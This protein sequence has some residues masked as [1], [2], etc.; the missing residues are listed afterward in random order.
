MAWISCLRLRVWPKKSIVSSSREGL[1]KDEIFCPFEEAN[2]SPVSGDSLCR[3]RPVGFPVHL[4]K[5]SE[6]IDTTAIVYGRA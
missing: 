3:I 1:S 2:H 5:E 6:G 4:I